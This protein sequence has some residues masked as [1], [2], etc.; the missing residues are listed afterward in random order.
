MD[1]NSFLKNNFALIYEGAEVGGK[2]LSYRFDS[3]INMKATL[4]VG[5]Y[6]E[7]TAKVMSYS[8]GQ[9]DPVK[10]TFRKTLK[11]NDD[12]K[13][14]GEDIGQ[15]PFFGNRRFQVGQGDIDQISVTETSI[16]HWADVINEAALSRAELSVY[17]TLETNKEVLG[18]A[19]KFDDKVNITNNFT[20]L[21]TLKG[22]YPIRA[23]I[24][25]HRGFNVADLAFTGDQ[26]VTSGKSEF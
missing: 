15:P 21:F 14:R 17:G 2:Y 10:F 8:L 23:E 9:S 20:K 25:S 18:A 7:G 16:Y 6:F 3:I 26:I 22:A 4:G 19:K 13:F 24:L 11:L 1:E 12:V 5:L